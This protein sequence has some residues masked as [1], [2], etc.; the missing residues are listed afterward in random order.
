VYLLGN[1]IYSERLSVGDSAVI[2]TQLF[3]VSSPAATSIKGDV[4][5]VRGQGEDNRWEV[6]IQCNNED[7]T[8]ATIFPLDYCF[9]YDNTKVAFKRNPRA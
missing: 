3:D 7:K 1:L 6:V 5:A 4:V 8:G 9:D 2:E